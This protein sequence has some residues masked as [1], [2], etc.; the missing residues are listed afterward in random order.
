ME[1]A[2]RYM[3]ETQLDCKDYIELLK[4]R[5][6][7]LLDRLPA[8]ADNERYIGM[9][10]LATFDKVESDSAKQLFY[11]CAYCA[12]EDIPLAMM[13]KARKWLPLPLRD[14]LEPGQELNCRTLRYLFRLSR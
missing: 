1:Y 6:L 11:L 2:A 4:K 12:S 5:G 14:V 3:R 13:A 8:I 10:W 7:E 9:T